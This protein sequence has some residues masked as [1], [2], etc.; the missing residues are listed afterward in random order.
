MQNQL[1]TNYQSKS[2]LELF[3][4]SIILT[5]ISNQIRTILNLEIHSSL[6][7]SNQYALTK[8]HGS[9]PFACLTEYQ[10][11]GRGRQGK[12][13]ISPYGSGICLSLKYR[14]QNLKLLTGLNIALVITVANSLYSLGI[15]DIGI[16]WPND[17]LW[18]QHKLAGL[19]LE[20]YCQANNY[21]IVYGIG[22]NVKMPHSIKTIDQPWVDLSTILG[23]KTISRNKLAA[24]LIDQCLQT[25]LNY[26]HQGL[27]PYQADWY[28]YDLSY[29]KPVSLKIAN[30]SAT[31]ISGIAQGINQQGALLVKIGKNVITYTDAEV[32]LRL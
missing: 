3:D 14:Y 7:S 18:H 8:Y 2:S 30:K 4:K 20:S 22:I 32:S 21:E 29:G 19:L 24:I 25:L 27:A 9:L 13:W 15:S 28:K 5:N 6:D 10:T 1:T 26:P 11:A 31:Y 12:S 16:K 17:I 23:N